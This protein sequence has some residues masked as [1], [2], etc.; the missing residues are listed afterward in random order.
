MHLELHSIKVQH[1]KIVRGFLV[2]LFRALLIIC[3]NDVHHC[4]ECVV[5]MLNVIQFNLYYPYVSFVEIFNFTVSFYS[6]F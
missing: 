6:K 5:L 3:E 1:R 2:L 4:L